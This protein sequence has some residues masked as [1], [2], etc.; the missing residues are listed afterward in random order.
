[1]LSLRKVFIHSVK[2]VLFKKIFN[3]ILHLNACF[4]TIFQAVSFHIEKNQLVLNFNED[5]FSTSI[6]LNEALEKVLVIFFSYIQQQ[7][8]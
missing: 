2:K 5:F 7:L 3:F 8:I 1:M 4:I 6:F